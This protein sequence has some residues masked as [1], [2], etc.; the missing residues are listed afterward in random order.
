MSDGAK[1]A[2]TFQKGYVPNR[3]GIK[4]RVPDTAH[5]IDD[6]PLSHQDHYTHSPLG[7]SDVTEAWDLPAHLSHT[8]KYL[9]R[10]RYKGDELGDLRKARW[11]LQRQIE[12]VEKSAL[13]PTGGAIGGRATP[14][15]SKEQ[16][17]VDK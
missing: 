6:D 12:L 17:Q 13:P 1:D 5:L 2:L 9:A 16:G 11:Y 14:G 10:Y 7:P 3:D 15:G 4:R 8:V